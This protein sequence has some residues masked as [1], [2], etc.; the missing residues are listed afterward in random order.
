MISQSSIINVYHQCIEDI[1]DDF[2]IPEKMLH[3]SGPNIQSR[4][5]GLKKTFHELWQHRYERAQKAPQVVADTMGN[6]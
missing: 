6:Q 4:V 2:H 5:E 1:E 3:H